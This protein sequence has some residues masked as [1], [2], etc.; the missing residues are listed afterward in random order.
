MRINDSLYQAMSDYVQEQDKLT[1]KECKDELDKILQS[2]I[3]KEKNE[4]RKNVLIELDKFSTYSEEDLTM[5]LW[6]YNR[7]NFRSAE[8]ISAKIEQLAYEDAMREKE[9]RDK[10]NALYYSSG[11][12]D[13][14][15]KEGKGLCWIPFGINVGFFLLG[16]SRPYDF[17]DMIFISFLLLPVSLTVTAIMMGIHAK[18]CEK[19]GLEHNVPFDSVSFQKARATQRSLKLGAIAGSISIY[20]TAKKN[21]NSLTHPDTWNILD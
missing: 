4:K 1:F 7:G 16:I 8:E 14:D 5:K 19:L 17:Y 12:Y 20:H 6:L 18:K 21:L 9:R 3:K 2:E 11:Q 13:A 15:C 10:A